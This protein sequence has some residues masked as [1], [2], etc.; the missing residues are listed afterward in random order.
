MKHTDG[1]CTKCG[2]HI[3]LSAFGLSKT[4]LRELFN[5]TIARKGQKDG[6]TGYE[7]FARALEQAAIRNGWQKLPKGVVGVDVEDQ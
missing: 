5:A 2:Q 6:L 7:R 3:Q 1:R 4:D